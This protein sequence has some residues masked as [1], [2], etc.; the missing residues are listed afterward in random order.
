MLNQHVQLYLPPRF[1]CAGGK[2]LWREL[3]LPI[4]CIRLITLLTYKPNFLEQK[5]T[6]HVLYNDVP[7]SRPQA[8][9]HSSFLL[10]DIP[11]AHLARCTSSMRR[12]SFWSLDFFSPTRDNIIWN[13]GACYTCMYVRARWSALHVCDARTRLSWNPCPRLQVMYFATSSRPA[14]SLV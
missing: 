5:M 11:E 1:F 12:T 6:A 13:T 3:L 9:L 8:W 4:F 10:S 14:E 2:M 7:M